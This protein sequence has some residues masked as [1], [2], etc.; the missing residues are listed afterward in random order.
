[1]PLWA[2]DLAAEVRPLQLQAMHHWQ[3]SCVRLAV[4]L[5]TDGQRVRVHHAE[6]SIAPREP[7]SALSHTPGCTP[8]LALVATWQAAKRRYAPSLP[9][10]PEPCLVQ[11]DQG[12]G[13]TWTAP[14][15]PDDLAEGSGAAERPPVA[16]A[17]VLP[18]CDPSS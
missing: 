15:E 16:S 1:M 18:G 12:S 14:V 2:C 11:L 6:Q 8:I 4:Q 10:N 17:W 5:C 9:P 3:V 7:P 13:C